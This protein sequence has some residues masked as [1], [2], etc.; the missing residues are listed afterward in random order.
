[1]IHKFRIERRV[2]GILNIRGA[3]L[4]SDSYWLL[5]ASSSAGASFARMLKEPR[6]SAFVHGSARDYRGFSFGDVSTR[7]ETSVGNYYEIP[8]TLARKWKTLSNRKYGS[9][10]VLCASIA[11]RSVLCFRRSVFTTHVLASDNSVSFQEDGTSPRSDT[12]ANESDGDTSD[13]DSPV[14]KDLPKNH[15]GESIGG[16]GRGCY[17]TRRASSVVHA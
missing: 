9:V 11:Q 12:C 16:S 6:N 3:K 15:S 14:S 7:E 1:M 2:R 10:F 17:Q 4:K 13:G 5:Y 8:G